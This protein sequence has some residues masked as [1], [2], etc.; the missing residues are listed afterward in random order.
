MK[1]ELLSDPSSPIVSICCITYNHARFIRDAIDGFLMQKTDFPVEI[2]IRDDASTDGTAEIIRRYQEEHPQLI[3]TIMH[4]ENQFSLGK[5][6]FPEVF[7][8]ARGKYIALCEGDD[9]W[10]DP[11]KLQKQVNFMEAHPECSVCCHEVEMYSDEKQEILGYF[12]SRQGTQIFK[13]DDFYRK[14]MIHTCAMLFKNLPIDDFFKKTNSVKIGD[15]A[16]QTFLVESGDIGFIDQCMSV[17][18]F[19]SGGIWN[20]N[21]KFSNLGKKAETM[22]TVIKV[23]GLSKNSILLRELMKLDFKLAVHYHDVG[24]SKFTKAYINKC[25]RLIKYFDRSRLQRLIKLSFNVYFPELNRV[26]T[27]LIQLFRKR[28]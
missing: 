8:M 7:A 28:P 2:I 12:P 22:E 10:T 9:Y 24:D 5:R 18:R 14:S 16:L 6:A 27:S 15:W 1:K 25:F 26:S 19:H 20:S 17:Y 11:L 3:R 4:T 21:D 23:L 13:S